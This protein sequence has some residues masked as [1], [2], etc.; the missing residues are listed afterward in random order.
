MK[1]LKCDLSGVIYDQKCTGC[2]ARKIVYLRTRDGRLSR[3]FQLV[4]LSGFSAS[5]KDEILEL[6]NKIDLQTVD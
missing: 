3:R 1:C 6:V 5:L 4:V 2:A